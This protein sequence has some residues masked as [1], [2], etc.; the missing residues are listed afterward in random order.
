MASVGRRELASWVA[1]STASGVVTVAATH[2]FTRGSLEEWHVRE[3]GVLAVVT[4]GTLL[5]GTH[6]PLARAVASALAAGGGALLG[7]SAVSRGGWDAVGVD[8]LVPNLCD[9]QLSAALWI[10]IVALLAGGVGLIATRI[11]GN[12][13]VGLALSCTT[14]PA[15]VWWTHTAVAYG[16]G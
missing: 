13:V 2:G 9:H 7:G 4:L 8:G 5:L 6:V 3:A 11:A 1:L 10:V 14:A 16:C 12:P 15:I